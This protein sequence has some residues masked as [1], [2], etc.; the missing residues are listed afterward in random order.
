MKLHFAGAGTIAALLLAAGPATA[1]PIPG[2][3]GSGDPF[4]LTFDESGDGD[5]TA[6]AGICSFTGPFMGTAIAG[7]GVSYA[8]PQAVEIGPVEIDDPNGVVSDELVFGPDSMA[9]YSLDCI[10]KLADTCG[11][12]PEPGAVV[13]TEAA[14]G[15]FVYLAGGAFPTG[16]AYHGQSDAVPEP[17]SF[18]VLGTAVIG[19]GAVRRRRRS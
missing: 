19:L 7:G 10:G 3:A 4:I 18:T 15:S 9:F 2:D 14:D 12:L 1:V 8:L 11:F 13:A 17:A 5:I 16:N 6:C